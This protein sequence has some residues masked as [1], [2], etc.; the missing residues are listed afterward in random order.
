MTTKNNCQLSVSVG[1]NPAQYNAEQVF[2]NCRSDWN[3]PFCKCAL[4]R[5]L[6]DEEKISFKFTR[7]KSKRRYFNCF[8]FLLRFRLSSRKSFK[9][10]LHTFLCW[11][12]VFAPLMN[13]FLRCSFPLHRQLSIGGVKMVQGCHPGNLKNGGTRARPSVNQVP[14]QRNEFVP[15]MSEQTIGASG[16]AEGPIYRDSKRYNTELVANFNPDI[17]FRDEELTNEDRMMTQV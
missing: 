12:L 8:N 4:S 16:P 2:N 13:D 14:F 11:T 7:A 6:V 10:F 5:L 1:S 17:V 9:F 3:P 15:K